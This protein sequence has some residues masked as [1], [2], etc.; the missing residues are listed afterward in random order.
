MKIHR[1]I[2]VFVFSL[3]A[4]SCPTLSAAQGKGAKGPV[5]IFLTYEIKTE[6]RA[7][8][9]AALLSEGVAQ[10][11]AWKT[12]GVFKNYL[13]LFPN[14][15]HM[16]TTRWDFLVILDFETYGDTDNWKKIERTAP[17][18]LSPKLLELVVPT[19][20]NLAQILGQAKLHDGVPERHVYSVSPYRFK[21]GAAAGVPYVTAYVQPQL[22]PFVREGVLAGY[23]LYLNSHDLTDWNYLLISEYA[24]TAAFGTR[25]KGAARG[26]LLDDPA[27]KGLHEIKSEIR[28]E[29]PMFFAERLAPLS[30]RQ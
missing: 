19:S 27:W 21:A 26:P 15:V 4:W 9:R 16:N 1:L 5:A 29:M 23:G 14:Y 12:A 8:A 25:N 7:R 24:D 30:N 20:T 2:A 10:F 17:G 22:D 18:G 6:N 28:E 13:L 3:I 11:E